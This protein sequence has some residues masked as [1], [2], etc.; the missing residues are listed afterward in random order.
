VRRITGRLVHKPSGRTYHQE[1][2]PPKQAGR[3]DVTGELL[4]HRNDDNVG[5]LKTR[6]EAYHKQT[7][8]LAA[9]YK[10]QGLLRVIDGKF[11]CLSFFYS[12]FCF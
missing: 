4:M 10:Q 6:L 7:A 11:V 8:P 12:T 5:A 9:Y 2:N 3:D 1:F